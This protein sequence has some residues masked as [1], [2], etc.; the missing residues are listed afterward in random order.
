[1]RTFAT[2]QPTHEFAKQNKSGEKG[3]SACSS[4]SLSRSVSSLSTGM[5]LLQRQCTCGGGCPRC[6]EE[7]RIQT[8]LKIGEPED[9]YEQEADRIADEVIRIPEPTIQRQV[10]PEEPEEEEMVQRKVIANQIAPLVQR[11]VLPE[12]EEEE[13]EEEGMAQRKEIANQVTPLTQEQESSE[14]PP[15]VH[16]VIHSP[17]KTLDPQT[18]CFMESRFGHDFTQVRVHTDGQAS[19]AAREIEA[20][21]FTY[22]R[23]I[24]FG[25]GEYAPNISA[26]RQLLAHELAHMV[27]Q[28]TAMTSPFHLQRAPDKKRKR[29]DVV[30]L[31]EGWEGG[32]E[33]SRVL[34]HGGQI[35]RVKSFGEVP[36]QLAKINFPIGTLYFVTHSTASGS[37]KFGSA[38]GFI[39]PADIADKLKGV[40]SADNAPGV[41]DFRGCSI[42]TS[43]KAMNQIRAALGAQTIVGG[44]CFA[45]ISRSSPIT[46]G[47]KK[48][49][50][51]SDV[52]DKN[53]AL[54]NKLKK[55]T[56][57][58][59]GAAKKCILNSSEKNFF[60]AG[61][62]FVLLWFNPTFTE[63]WIPSKSICY[64]DI[65]P[66]VVNPDKDLSESEGCRLIRVDAPLHH[67]QVE[68]REDERRVTPP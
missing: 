45:V 41:V 56:V 17:G 8:K 1:M 37:L 54:F 3:R 14:V 43:P 12:I 40:V 50:K 57:D 27:Q 61:G 25:N 2:K 15:I 19:K 38:E 7:L 6:K 11:Q 36:V 59:F 24:V 34:A 22:G 51:S 68:Y 16:E 66:Q 20:R 48:I 33:L 9:K 28:T 49:T 65:T 18:R 10:E 30:V 5:P 63:K 46:I 64:T 67:Q 55:E 32:E 4:A 29:R 62:R 52:T 53:R 39:E 31:G 21:A 47:G 58:Q 13:D 60:A 35:I 26:G 44:N 23:D 42:G